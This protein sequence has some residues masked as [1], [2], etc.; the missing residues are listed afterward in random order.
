MTSSWFLIH[1]EAFV[2]VSKETGLEV[3]AITLSTWLCLEIRMQ[4]EI[5]A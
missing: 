3:N 4:N 1:A 5:T 2:V